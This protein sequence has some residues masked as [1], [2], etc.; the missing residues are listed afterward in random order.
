[1]DRRS[2]IDKVRFVLLVSGFGIAVHSGAGFSE[3]LE[4]LIDHRDDFEGASAVAVS[5]FN[6]QV[7]YAGDRRGRISK[8]E[9]EGETWNSLS[10]PLVDSDSRIGDVCQRL[11]CETRDNE[12]TP[13][14]PVRCI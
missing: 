9:D 12:W 14:T 3:E 6:P 2:P 8:S 11:D 7:V 4:I 1:M 10:E 5:P 13:S